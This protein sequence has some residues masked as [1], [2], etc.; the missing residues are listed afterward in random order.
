MVAGMVVSV[1]VRGCR[2]L[3]IRGLNMKKQKPKLR[4]CHFCKKKKLTMIIPPRTPV[5]KSCLTKLYKLYPRLKNGDTVI[6]GT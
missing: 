2:V 4:Q 3:P 5:C 1:I 6:W